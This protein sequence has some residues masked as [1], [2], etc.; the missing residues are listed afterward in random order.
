MPAW[1]DDKG[2]VMYSVGDFA[3]EQDAYIAGELYQYALRHTE[4]RNAPKKVYRASLEE[5]LIPEGKPT[6]C[7]KDLDEFF[8]ANRHM[9]DLT[10]FYDKSF[11]D[12]L[13][14][15]ATQNYKKF[16]EEEQDEK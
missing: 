8:I 16:A 10:R 4:L 6:G 3:D 7:Y 14:A 13:V 12:N 1:Y 2:M 15:T 9:R 11:V 5:S